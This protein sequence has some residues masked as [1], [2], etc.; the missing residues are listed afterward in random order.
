METQ[1]PISVFPATLALLAILLA[2]ASATAQDDVR[3][4]EE[5]R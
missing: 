1:S 3:L 2:A 5:S 4:Q